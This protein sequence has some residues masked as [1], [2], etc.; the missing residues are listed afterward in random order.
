[1]AELT[2]LYESKLASVNSLDEFRTADLT[3]DPDEIVPPDVRAKYLA[4]PDAVRVRDREVP[5]EYDVEDAAGGVARLR[6]PEKL[7][8]TLSESEL[9]EFDRPLRFVV[10]RGQ[11][12]AV[13]AASLDELQE[14]LDRPWMADE[15][16]VDEQRHARRDRNTRRRERAHDRGRSRGDV[17]VG[18][19]ESRRNRGHRGVDPPRRRPR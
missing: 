6:L 7:A 8:R 13:R 4:L 11:R 19:R 2:A 9:P 3:I 5:I 12:G 15:I 1:L 17:R 14:L 18:S 16:S 10:P